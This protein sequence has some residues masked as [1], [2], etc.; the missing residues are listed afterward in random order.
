M[1][2]TQ[3][4]DA[5][6]RLDVEFLHPGQNKSE[7]V[8]YTPEAL[9][10]GLSCSSEARLRLALIPLFLQHPQLASVAPAALDKLPRAAQIT[11]RCYYCAAVFLQQKYRKRLETLFGSQP[12]LPPLFLKQM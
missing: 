9:I 7:G 3:L 5:L 11:L 8:P 2:N 1:N 10:S 6:N 12:H 4:A